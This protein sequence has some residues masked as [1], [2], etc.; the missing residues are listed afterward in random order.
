MIDAILGAAPPA[1]GLAVPPGDDAAVLADGTAVTVD[2]LVEGIH[3][4]HRLSAADVGWKTVAASVSD[5]AATGARPDWAVLAL[6]LPEPLDD[7]WVAGFAR[8]LADALARWSI[9]LV[10]GDTTRSPVRTVSLTLA[11]PCV[12]QPLRRAAARPG[13]DLWVT[14][15]PGLAGAGWMWAAPPDPA[16]AALR[17]PD[18]PLAFALDLARRDVARAAMDLS[19]GLAADLPRMC[20]ASGAGAT[21]DRDAIPVHPDLAGDPWPAVFGGGDDYQ[22]LFAAPPAAR[23][24]VDALAREHGVRAAR[25]GRFHAGSGARL[26]GGSWPAPAFAHW[27][28]S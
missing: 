5:L 28:S 9:R 3:W 24:A 23:D 18:P 17:R 20:A 2:A 11:G 8:G 4:D 6:S 25:I 27:S 19:D 13:D 1:A 22:L 14:G 12:A 7:A 26:A 15:W 21:V 16:L 10:G